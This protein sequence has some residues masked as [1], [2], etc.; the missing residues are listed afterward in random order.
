V[1]TGD[2]RQ[3]VAARDR[4]LEQAEQAGQDLGPALLQALRDGD[5]TAAQALVQAH[6]RRVHELTENLRIYQA[7]LHAQADELHASQLRAQQV[8]ERFAALFAGM[9]VAAL[10]V[11]ANG[12]VLEHNRLAEQLLQLR[13]LASVRF[14]HRLVD[15]DH[16]QAAVRPALRQ[17]QAQGAARVDS[18]LFVGERG[19]RFVGELHLSRLTDDGPGGGTF[20]CAVIDRTEQLRSLQALEEAAS[21]LQE[22]ESFLADAA[23]VARTGG[24]VLT[25]RPR[26]LRWSTQ[27]QALMELPADTPA[28]LETLLALCE[29]Q[30]RPALAGALAHSE[31]GEPFELELDMRSARGRPM[32]VLAVGQ[33]EREGTQVLRVHGVLQDISTQHLER[34]QL[35]DLSDRLAMAN[36]AGGIGVWDCDL[37]SGAVV[38]D[39]RMQHLLGLVASP[40]VQ[41][42]LALLAP[43]L[44]PDSKSLL[45][46]ALDAALR[47]LEPL[48]LELHL[49]D[50]SGEPAE[51]WLHLT[52]RAHADAAGRAVRLVGCA[53][54]SS[55]QHEALRLLAA[56]EAAESASRAKSAFLS[57]MSHELRT[58]LNAILGFSQLMRLEADAGDL[59]LKPHRVQLIESAA[60][61]LL[62]LVNEVLDVT[63]IESG[64]L[65]VQLSPLDPLDVVAEAWP[66]VQGQAER[67]GVRLWL[68]PAAPGQ[69]AAVRADRLRLKQVLINLLSNAVKYNLP[70]GEVR[71]SV[72]ATDDGVR[73]VV[74]DTGR[75]MTA[76]Q[77]AGLFQPFNRVG[78]EASGIEGTGMGLFVC[79]RFVELMGGAIEVSTAPGQGSTFS[80][81]LPPAA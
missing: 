28:A 77:V 35:G 9:P 12:E 78:A 80:V 40:P 65:D 68:R 71:V 66:L 52:G 32:R 10:L 55:P 22:S 54:D 25:L 4:L 72:Q 48:N 34:R 1:S 15:A 5:A 62:E 21:A 17:A 13:P 38:L 75:G 20:A 7:E 69:A 24:W 46:Q 23:R 6:E 73:L 49:V 53:W 14:L 61:H 33:P 39:T 37:R 43:H 19:Q 58:P 79:Q 26:D 29:P 18:L 45:E 16:Y 41:G 36:D 67:A 56:K 30:D 11:A 42:L 57:R 81:R 2:L 47:H 3:R 31:R 8:L 50:R 64:R 51:R 63:R 76:E 60:R 44:L 70:G 59:V 74:A 27:L